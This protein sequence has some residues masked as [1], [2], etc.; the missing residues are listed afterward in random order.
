MNALRDK[1]IDYLSRREHSRLE[2]K[3][4]LTQKE[5]DPTEIETVLTQ[6][7]EKNLQSDE[8]FAQSYVRYRQQAGF[9][10]KR[11]AMELQE[12]GV[13]DALISKHIDE[14][15]EEWIELLRIAWQKKYS[16]S[17]RTTKDLHKK[18][19]QFRFLLHRGYTLETIRKFVHA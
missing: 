11:I 10:P 5:F 15:S 7:I 9:G 4:K 14:Q 1:A 2:L 3:R 19:Q 6:L 17:E 12:R 18:H 16:A 13:S 8:R